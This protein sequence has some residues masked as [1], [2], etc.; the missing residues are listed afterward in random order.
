MS[1]AALLA[2]GP[3]LHRERPTL[4]R[5][6]RGIAIVV[7][8]LGRWGL[9]QGERASMHLRAVPAA[10]FVG[11]IQAGRL[12]APNLPS[13]GS[14]SLT[15]A[16]PLRPHAASSFP[17]V[18]THVISPAYRIRCPLTCDAQHRARPAAHQ[19]L[20]PPPPPQLLPPPKLVAA[21]WLPAAAMRSRCTGLRASKRAT[22]WTFSSRPSRRSSCG[23]ARWGREGGAV[24][25][26]QRGLWPAGLCVLAAG[27]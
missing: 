20:P 19:L 17:A 25:G 1:A 6:S 11:R 13:Q 24:S 21:P 18:A 12:L 5:E 14:C 8:L 7:G 23:A 10:G 26:Q 2:C 15:P 4:P 22:A 27:A 16:A 9:L 3:L